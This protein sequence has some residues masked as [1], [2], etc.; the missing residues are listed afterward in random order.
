MCACAHN[1]NLNT[2]FYLIAMQKA[3]AQAIKDRGEKMR[4]KNILKFIIHHFKCNLKCA[5]FLIHIFKSDGFIV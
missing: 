3:R 4:M 1:N 5:N 2:M